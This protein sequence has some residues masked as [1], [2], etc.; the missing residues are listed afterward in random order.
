[1][2]DKLAVIQA[3]ETLDELDKIDKKTVELVVSFKSLYSETE[4]INGI[5]C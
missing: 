1:M 5:N 4:R 3:T 2:A